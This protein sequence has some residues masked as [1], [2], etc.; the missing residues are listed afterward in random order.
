MVVEWRCGV[1]VWKGWEVRV[2]VAIGG[3]RDGWWWMAEELCVWR[4]GRRVPV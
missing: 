1:G 2:V 4:G 3:K